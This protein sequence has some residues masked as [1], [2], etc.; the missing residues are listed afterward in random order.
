M[1]MVNGSSMV[2]L[3]NKEKEI[4]DVEVGKGSINGRVG[5]C[6]E[7][8]ETLEKWSFGK[9]VAFSNSLGTPT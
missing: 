7:R 8:E 5:G 1:I 4:V 6:A 9:L 2:L 3:M